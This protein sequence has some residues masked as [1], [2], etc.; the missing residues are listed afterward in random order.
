MAPEDQN[1]EAIGLTLKHSGQS[2]RVFFQLRSGPADRERFRNLAMSLEPVG[3]SCDDLPEF[4]AKCVE[5]FADH[6][7]PRVPM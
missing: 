2:V 6:G 7:F 1:L 5:L 4:V 3:R